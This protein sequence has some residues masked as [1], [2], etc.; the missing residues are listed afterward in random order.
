[1]ITREILTTCSDR[2]NIVV[3]IL[4]ISNIQLLYFVILGRKMVWETQ[5]VGSSKN[6]LLA[7]QEYDYWS[8]QGET[9]FLNIVPTKS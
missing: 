7:H 6:G 2:N 9:I 4:T 1:M 5:R 3:L 8:H